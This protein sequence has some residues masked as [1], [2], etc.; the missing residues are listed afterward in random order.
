MA[1]LYS[2]LLFK[3][4]FK[5]SFR[6]Y[7]AYRVA[8]LVPT[9]QTAIFRFCLVTAKKGLVDLRRPFCST[10]SQELIIGVI[11]VNNYKGHP[12]NDVPLSRAQK[13]NAHA[14]KEHR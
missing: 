10:D 8:S 13:S 2:E 5:S 11:G 3:T 7:G 14:T 12:L 4:R 1:L 9:S 6:Q